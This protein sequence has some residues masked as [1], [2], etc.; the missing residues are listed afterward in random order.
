MANCLGWGYPAE[1]LTIPYD[2]EIEFC[3]EEFG[4]GYFNVFH[5]ANDVRVV[6]FI[7]K[8]KAVVVLFADPAN[9]HDLFCLETEPIYYEKYLGDQIQLIK[10]EKD[11]ID[12]TLSKKKLVRIAQ[13]H[14]L[15][16]K[17]KEDYLEQLLAV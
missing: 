7:P 5:T 3:R 16:K 8:E 6:R 15:S 4:D 13:E 14:K 17:L 12:N 11:T 9:G 10:Q 2:H 1:F